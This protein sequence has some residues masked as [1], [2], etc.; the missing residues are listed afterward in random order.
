MLTTVK[1]IA[2]WVSYFWCV[3]RKSSH[4]F[5]FI[6]TSGKSMLRAFGRLL[7]PIASRDLKGFENSRAYAMGALCQI[8]CNCSPEDF[9]NLDVSCFY[10]VLIR[11][12]NEP[13]DRPVVHKAIRNSTSLFSGLLPASR[14]LI[15]YFLPHLRR[16]FEKSANSTLAHLRFSSLQIISSLLSVSN[17]FIATENDSDFCKQVVRNQHQLFSLPSILINALQLEK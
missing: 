10:D 6:P 4:P 3:D 11:A 8:F 9:S 16:I 17:N 1:G 12:L 7:F 13:S 5:R 2:E 15:P 14:Y